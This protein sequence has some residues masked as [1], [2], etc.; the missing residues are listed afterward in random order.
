MLGR[1]LRH[2]R[3]RSI[4]W[5]LKVSR[6]CSYHGGRGHLVRSVGKLVENERQPC[7]GCLMRRVIERLTAVQSLHGLWQMHSDDLRVD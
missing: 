5:I 1:V 2:L 7:I 6:V 3:R 4:F